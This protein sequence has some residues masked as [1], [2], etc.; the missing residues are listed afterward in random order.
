VN[1]LGQIYKGMLSFAQKNKERMPWQLTPAGI[2]SNFDSRVIPGMPFGSQPTNTVNILVHHPVTDWTAG[3]LMIS[4]VKRELQTPKIFHSPTDPTRQTQQELFQEWWSGL[5]ARMV[6]ELPWSQ[7][8]PYAIGISKALSYTFVLGG[9]TQRPTS[10]LACTRNVDND[11]LAAARWLGSDKDLANDRTMAGLTYSQGQL[12]Q[13][14]GSAK[15]AN[16]ADIGASGG[17]TRAAGTATGGCATGA[18]SLQTIRDAGG[19]DL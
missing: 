14:D 2:R 11:N 17:I 1:N 8:E 18:T 10:V 13:M 5:D 9:D 3:N 4:T 6:S 15:Q 19:G 12:V 7:V 16:N